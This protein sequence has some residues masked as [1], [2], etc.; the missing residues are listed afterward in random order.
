[1]LLYC[2]CGTNLTRSLSTKRVAIVVCHCQSSATCCASLHFSPAE[3]SY[4]SLSH[5]VGG[6]ENI[7]LHFKKY[8]DK[9]D[10]GLTF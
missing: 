6:K 4:L 1:M 5:E 9:S 2:H 8:K 10:V 3:I 7:M